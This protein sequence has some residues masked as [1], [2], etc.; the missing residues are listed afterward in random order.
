MSDIA[1]IK[2]H[3]YFGLHQY[4]N[5]P[6]RYITFIRNPVKRVISLYRYLRQ[7]TH[8]KQHTL[9]ANK[10]LAEFVVDCSLHNNGQT[11]F[12]AG[13]KLLDSPELLLARAQENLHNHFTVVGLT[14]RF[15]ESLVLFKQHLNW[16]N[17]PTYTQENVSDKG[18]SNMV[19]GKT[20][21][22]IEKYNAADILLYQYAETLFEQ[23]IQ[24]FCG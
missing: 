16:A 23:Q 24:Q 11:R 22:L 3:M 1:C 15:D 21:A 5:E 8:H 6:S 14:E 20:L 19:D 18:K 12:L 2:G 9:A 10:S 17:F 7:S 4:L 13:G